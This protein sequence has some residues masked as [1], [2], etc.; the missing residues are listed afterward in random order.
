[1]RIFLIL[2]FFF[3]RNGSIVAD[4]ELI[5]NTEHENYQMATA[6]ALTELAHNDSIEFQNQTLK[7][8]KIMVSGKQCKFILT[9]LS[10]IIHILP[11]LLNDLFRNIIMN[12]MT[13]KKNKPNI[14]NNKFLAFKNMIMILPSILSL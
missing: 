5:V 3:I 12:Y 11:Q 9:Q 8:T 7:A 1:M 13:Y 10:F 14:D 4:Y 2:R 6:D